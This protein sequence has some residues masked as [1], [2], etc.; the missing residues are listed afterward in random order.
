MRLLIPAIDSGGPLLN[1]RGEVIGINTQKLV[2]KN[3][4]GI[5]FALSASDLIE[6]LHRFYPTSVPPAEKLPAPATPM[7]RVSASPPADGFGTIVFAH[8]EGAEIWVDHAFVG[9]IPAT[10]K[11]AAGNHLIVIR[12]P[13]HADWIHSI[14]VLKDSQANVDPH[15]G[16]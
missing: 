10:L 16:E 11:L 15:L 12:A 2:K 6:V 4:N 7:E 8:P 14:D 13:S 1:A 3:L 9:S 5:G